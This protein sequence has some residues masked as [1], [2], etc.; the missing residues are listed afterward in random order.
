MRSEKEI[1]DEDMNKDGESVESP[2]FNVDPSLNADSYEEEFTSNKNQSWGRILRVLGII[3][4]VV[5]LVIGLIFGLNKIGVVEFGGQSGDQQSGNTEQS[6]ESDLVQSG[7]VSDEAIQKDEDLKPEA[8]RKS[9]T[10]ERIKEAES[11]YDMDWLSQQDDSLN[12]MKS[13]Y[14]GV[15]AYN[16]NI[17][18]EWKDSYG[19]QWQTMVTGTL[20]NL[21]TLW[22]DPAFH[23]KAFDVD[24]ATVE[25]RMQSL[26]DVSDR[27]AFMNRLAPLSGFEWAGN[28]DK[29]PASAED[30]VYYN[31]VVPVLDDSGKVPG[32]NYSP[33]S[34]D[35]D[36]DI[37]SISVSGNDYDG[38]GVYAEYPR[39]NV[40]R[41]VS[42][43]GGSHVATQNLTVFANNVDGEW[44]L[45][46]I[47]AGPI[48]MS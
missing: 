33:N 18:Q 23:G 7:E 6:G 3:V 41:Q 45:I 27:D 48:S 43:D 17:P 16:V 19:D 8:F 9:V 2:A 38:E 12:P 15:Y 46:E 36:A 29:Q 24:A 5:A 22:G 39:F 11:Q 28:K 32:T 20:S 26:Y 4:G 37:L 14:Y 35:W 21:S 47:Q 44:K 1:V 31:G 13:D 10:P 34:T 40:T 30:Y 42:Y 25:T